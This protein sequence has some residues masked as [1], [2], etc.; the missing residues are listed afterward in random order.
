MT[1]PFLMTRSY[2]MTVLLFTAR[3]RRSLNPFRPPGHRGRG[4]GRFVRRRIANADHEIP[5]RDRRRR[6]VAEVGDDPV[7]MRAES[8]AEQGARVTPPAPDVRL[9]EVVLQ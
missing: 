5:V 8:R 6:A 1:V 7:A 2:A 9:R 4:V 3:D